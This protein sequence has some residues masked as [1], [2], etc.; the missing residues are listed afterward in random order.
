MRGADPDGALRAVIAVSG[1][2]VTVAGMDELL[3]GM[4]RAAAAVPARM[5][6]AVRKTGADIV[7][8]A[9]PLTP[10]DTGATV[11]S[12]GSDVVESD[13]EVESTTGPQTW[14]APLLE[15]GTERMAPRPFMG[16]AFDAHEPEFVEAIA[17]TS[18][19]G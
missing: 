2:E 6:L 7:A 3:A 15:N 19:L 8:T 14:Y 17:Q 12:I 10:V 13:T 16:P 5:S 4:E 11:N 18:P 1:I 9:Q